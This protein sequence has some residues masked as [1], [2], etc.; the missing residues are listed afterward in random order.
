MPGRV[1]VVDVQVALGA[2]RDVDQAVAAELLQHVVEEAD[3][4]VDVVDAG[5]VEVDGGGDPRLL[6]RALDERPPSA[7]ARRGERGHGGLGRGLL[8][9]SFFNGLS[10]HRS[11]SGFAPRSYRK[12]GGTVERRF[13]GTKRQ[14]ASMSSPRQ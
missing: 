11:S 6:G 12:P 9:S 1:V 2:Q 14:L 3:A 8:R 10:G 5:A 13:R 7:A 4:G